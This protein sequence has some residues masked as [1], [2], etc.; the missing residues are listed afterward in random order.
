MADRS[1][2][3]AR[4]NLKQITFNHK[5]NMFHTFRYC[6]LSLFV[7]SLVGCSD[8]Q[9]Y[10][11]VPFEGTI[12]YKG[13]PLEKVSL[14]FAVESYRNSGASV[15][16]DGKFK[17]IHSPSVMGIPVGKCTLKIGWAGGSENAPPEEYKELFEKYGLDSPGYVFEVTKAEK[18]FK[19][20]LE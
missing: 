8:G 13:K 3:N 2:R 14:D 11:V 6:L 5:T 15:S 20:E 7:L 10:K 17:A 1:R 4:K 16:A 9:K 19:I 18:D 12:T